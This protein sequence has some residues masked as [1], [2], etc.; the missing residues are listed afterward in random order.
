MITPYWLSHPSQYTASLRDTLDIQ[1]PVHT[2]SGFTSR[3]PV[4]PTARLAPGR[5]ALAL[6]LALSLSLITSGW[7]PVDLPQPWISARSSSSPLP[8]QTSPRFAHA[9]PVT[10]SLITSYS[11][12][13]LF[14]NHYYSYHQLPCIDSACPGLNIYHR[15]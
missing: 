10:H 8:G 14:L 3:L 15:T 5:P 13:H 12:N 2:A 4:L 7:N 9:A 11:W 6:A 1:L